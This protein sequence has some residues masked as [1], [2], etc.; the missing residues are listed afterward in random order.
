MVSESEWAVNIRRDSYT[1]Y[2]GHYPMF[3]YFGIAE[4][5]SKEQYNFMQMSPIS[6]RAGEGGRASAS[7]SGGDVPV[8]GRAMLLWLSLALL[9]ILKMVMADQIVHGDL[10]GLSPFP[11]PIWP[12]TVRMSTRDVNGSRTSGYP[13]ETQPIRPDPIK[14]TR[15][16]SGR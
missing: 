2:I 14:E 10:V 6:P 7:H 8:K 11:A 1:S 5:E 4:N 9:L 15:L 3:P 13:P 16:K 12:D